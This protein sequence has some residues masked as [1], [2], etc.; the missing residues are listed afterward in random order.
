VDYDAVKNE[1]RKS[2]EQVFDLQLVPAKTE[3]LI[4]ITI[5]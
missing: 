3:E 4:P 1:M 5:A 2:F